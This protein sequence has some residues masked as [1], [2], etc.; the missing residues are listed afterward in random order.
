MATSTDLREDIQLALASCAKGNLMASAKTLFNALGYESER[1][2]PWTLETF[3]E[4]GSGTV[5]PL[6]NKDQADLRRLKSLHLLFQVGDQELSKHGD[7]FDSSHTIDA[8]RIQSYIFFAAELPHGTYTRGDLTT[9]ARLINKPLPMPAIVLFRH[10]EKDE[11]LVSI[12][13]IRRRLNKRDSA[14][15]VLDKATLIKDIRCTDPIR[16]H[17]EILNDFALP[18]LREFDEIPNFVQLHAAWEKRL[19]SYALSNAFYREIADW[20]FWALHQVEDGVIRLPEHCDTEQEKSLFL[21]RL[22]TRMIFCWFLVEK[23]LIPA[24]LF[25]VHSLQK[26]I[27]DFHPATDP[28]KPDSSPAYYHAILQNLFFGTLNMP[29]EQRAFRERKKEGERYDPNFGITTLWRFESTFHSSTAW[30][31]HAKRV[32]FLN[33]GLFDC[34]D[35]KSGKKTDNT[36]LDGFSDNPKLSCHLPNDLFFGP[37]RTVDLSKDYGEEDKRTARSKKAKVRGLIEILSRYKF[38]I[39]ENTPLEEEIALD[40]ELLGKVFENL[41]ASYNE[42]T[43]TTARKALGA[44]YTP[45]E[46]VTYMVDES[47]KSYLTSQVPKCKGALEDLFSNKA[48]LKEIQPATRTALIDAIGRVKILDPACGSGAFPMGA[49][50]RLVDLLQKLDPENERWREVQRLRALAETEVAF[51]SGDR[52][53]REQRLKEINNTFEFNSSDYGRK[54]Y[55]IENAIYGVDIQPVAV[56]IAKLRFFIALVVDQRVCPKENNLGV[57]PLPNLETRLVAADTL[58]P[59]PRPKLKQA[60]LFGDDAA[61]HKQV[62]QLKQRLQAVRHEHFNARDP[63][64]KRACK[65][66]DQSIRA[67]LSA[68]LKQTGMDAP[69]AAKLA[70]W[71]PYDQNTFAPFFDSEWMFGLP[72][73]KVRLD[74][75]GTPATLRGNLGLINEASGQ[76]ELTETAVKLVDSGFDV[77][78]GNPPYIRIQTLKQKDPEIVAFYKDH[79]A[80]AAKGNYD[81]YVVFIEAGLNLLKSD[82]QLAYICPHKFF[83]SEYGEP[84]RE[85]ISNGKHLRHVV[86]FGEQQ[87]FPGASIYTCLLFL[88]RSGATE[89]Q[90]VRAA[91][92][93]AWKS[94]LAGIDGKFPATSI[95]KEK[96][97]FAVGKG[98]AVFELLQRQSR[99]LES[100]TRRIF[101]GIKTSADKIYIVEERRRTKTKLTIYSPQTEKVH[102]VEPD[103]FHPLIKGG[104][105]RSYL[106][107]KTDRLILFPYA[108]NQSGEAELISAAKFKKNYPLTWAYLFANRDYLQKREDGAFSGAN[109]Y[110]YGRSQALDVMPLP[111]LFTPDL[112]LKAS[113]AFDETGELFFTGGVAGGYGILPKEGVESKW[114]L[115]LLNSHVVDF[116]HHQIAT[117]MRGGWYSY[118]SRFIKG[119]PIANANT[120]Q[121]RSIIR[122]V[123]VLL[124]SRF[125]FAAYPTDQTTRDPLMLAYWERVL[126]GLVYELYFPEE[127]HGAGLHL[128]DLVEKAKLPDVTDLAEKDRLARLRQKF[129][130]LHDGAHSLR[131]ALDKLQTLD[132]VRIIEGKV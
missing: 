121:T 93:E 87:V 48:T 129:E 17:L 66:Q 86:H 20:Y 5:K 6:T 109:W 29:P 46:I 78:I 13:I 71:D 122:C 94:T 69:A 73:G 12:A 111:K 30:T 39:E 52:E 43:K 95:S 132:T 123:D 34:L 8:Q 81:I 88:A 51:K 75:P 79:Y 119:L 102:D 31:A 10:G 19:D 27:K 131:I 127:I 110:A 14:K 2:A 125:H 11:P 1:T 104:D 91:D 64:K 36:I 101:Q 126:N 7:L 80:S 60:S 100:V 15:D 24:D 116:F 68:V 114:L 107:T 45:R 82:G 35:D 76:S 98:R 97:N 70:A 89:C 103:L 120:G 85:V 26:L 113:I 90:F 72:I 37:E 118:E 112:A 63:R 105:S 77:V 23:R 99:T 16:A 55:L 32:P 53:I 61:S 96:W 130:E 108:N 21:I 59:I 67:E 74:S 25:R 57:R 18:S 33:G 41:L 28:K 83:N 124:A 4:L 117:Q 62:E 65:E 54:L 44:F 56:Q 38:T 58:I 22:L 128:F 92:L 115:A 84:I 47:L 9:I 49:L 42:D 106:L 3:I 40:P 50:H